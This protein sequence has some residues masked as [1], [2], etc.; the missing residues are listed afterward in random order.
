[1]A[2]D[3]TTSRPRST[4]PTWESNDGSRVV[5]EV[6][7]RSP[8]QGAVPWLLLSAKSNE[9]AGVLAS[10]KYI[11]RV[12]TIGASHR[13]RAATGHMQAPKRASI[14]RPTTISTGRAEVRCPTG[15]ELAR[16]IHQ[17]RQA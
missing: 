7:Q 17:G 10:A 6:A 4:G 5:G 15:L 16:Y 2:T 3:T 9:G 12:D 13:P 8:V 14:T 1:M 11:R